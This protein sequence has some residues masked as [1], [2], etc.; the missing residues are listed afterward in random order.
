MDA[1]YEL[2]AEGIPETEKIPPMVLH[3]LVENA[4]THAF[5]VGENGRFR[6]TCV[7]DGNRVEYRFSNDGSL[8]RSVST[9][10]GNP[11]MEGTGYQYIRAR[12][13]E[14]YPGRWTLDYGRNGS[15]WEVVIGIKKNG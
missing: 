5:E 13:E 6:L 4:L 8:L 3:T 7:G 9:S 10:T 15:R 11:Q 12:L 14:S 2:D 1:R